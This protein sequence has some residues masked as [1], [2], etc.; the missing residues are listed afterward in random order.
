M[1]DAS[2][3]AGMPRP[4]CR[5][6][7]V[8]YICF[9]N[10]KEVHR[11]HAVGT[12]SAIISVFLIVGCAG[13]DKPSGKIFDS[14][15][16]DWNIRFQYR[17]TGDGYLAWSPNRSMSILDTKTATYSVGNGRMH[18]DATDDP[19]IWKGTWV[20]DSRSKSCK[21]EK[22]G[23][24]IWGMQTIQFNEAYDEFKGTWDE[25]GEGQKFDLTGVR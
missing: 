19:Y 9:Y 24:T 1:V 18:F 12:I 13:V 21:T 23:S 25:C 15:L 7:Q 11:M 5:L 2:S 6:P 17:R 14:P 22:H 16:G 20:Q 4:A 10:T 8:N 3:P